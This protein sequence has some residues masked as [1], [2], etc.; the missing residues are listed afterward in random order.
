M[1]TLLCNISF[2]KER[3]IMVALYGIELTHCCIKGKV[4]FPNEDIFVFEVDA[5][6]HAAL[7]IL[8]TITITFV[9]TIVEQRSICWCFASVLEYYV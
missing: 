1:P 8:R 9:R 3:E 5:T 2:W 6:S 4:F 7:D